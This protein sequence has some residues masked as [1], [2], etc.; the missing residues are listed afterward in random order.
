MINSGRGADARTASA[1]LALSRYEETP[2]EIAKS[3]R[4]QNR[5]YHIRT[6]LAEL[7]IVGVIAF[8]LIPRFILPDR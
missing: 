3:G 4:H 8:F 6:A 2:S 7:K 1:G 5:Q